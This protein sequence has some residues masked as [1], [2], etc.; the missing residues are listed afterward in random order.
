MLTGSA[1]SDVTTVFLDLDGTLIDPKPGI[2]RSFQHAL[3]QM[4]LPVPDQNDLTWT[5]GP[6]IRDSLLQLGVSR[7]RLDEAVHHYRDH[8]TGQG[9]L[10]C[11]V[12]PAVPDMLADLRSAGHSLCLATSKPLVFARRITR[13]FGLDTPMAMQFG[14][15]LDGTRDDKSDLLAHALQVTGAMPE[16]CIMIGDRRFDVLGAQANGIATIGALWGYGGQAELNAAGV[17]MLAHNPADI[18]GLITH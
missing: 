11:T 2:T 17:D 9:L 5:I 6:P 1:T 13:H 15:E 4:G 8:Y 14:S 3:A 10:D 18:P 12:Y 7:P 16:T